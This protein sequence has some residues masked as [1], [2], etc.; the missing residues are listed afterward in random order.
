MDTKV[1]GTAEKLVAML[2]ENTGR[3]MLDSGDAYGRAWE[4][5]QGRDLAS[6]MSEPT[7]VIDEYGT[8]LNLFHWLHERLSYAPDIDAMWRAYDDAHPDDSW[9]ESAEAWKSLVGEDDGYWSSFGWVNSYNSDNY[10]NGTIQFLPFTLGGES[11]VLLQIHGGCD[12]RG[13]YTKPVVFS[14]DETVLMFSDMQLYCSKG[15][16]YVDFTCGGI[17]DTDLD[18][19]SDW[20]PFHGCPKCGDAMQ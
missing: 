20:E 13:G 2:T 7:A 5:N 12:V 11:Y 16:G 3:S 18:V 19:P 17:Q 10:L 9:F 8:G 15:C 14:A 4:R 6:F 1:M